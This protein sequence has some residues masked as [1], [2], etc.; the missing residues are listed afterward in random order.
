MP[1]ATPVT[2][3]VAEPTVAFQGAEDDHTP[4]DVALV[5]VTVDPVH[6]NGEP[7]IVPG[8]GFTVTT[9]VLVHSTRV[10]VT[11]TVPLL[12]PVSRPVDGLI[13]ATDGVPTLQVPPAINAETLM[14]AEEPTHTVDEPPI[15]V[16]VF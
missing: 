8:S 13:D 14:V 1:E 16:T 9:F 6:V 2:T 12:I 4:P 15:E 5:S 3:P 11:S 7:E 10:Y